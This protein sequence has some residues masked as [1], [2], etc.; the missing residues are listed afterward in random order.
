LVR[1]WLRLV[2]STY[3]WLGH[4]ESNKYSAK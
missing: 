2:K 4:G 3:A 1:T